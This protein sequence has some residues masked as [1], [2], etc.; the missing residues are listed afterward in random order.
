MVTLKPAEERRDYAQ[1]HIHM[2]LTSTTPQEKS[3]VESMPFVD[4]HYGTTVYFFVDPVQKG[5]SLNHCSSNAAIGLHEDL[6]N[7]KISPQ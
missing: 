3:S 6:V 7:A 4:F 1:G 5:L 2:F